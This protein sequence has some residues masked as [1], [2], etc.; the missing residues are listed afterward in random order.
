MVER[1]RRIRGYPPRPPPVP[2]PP[3]TPDTPMYLARRR[4]DDRGKRLP[5]WKYGPYIYT[6][7]RGD[8]KN[9]DY[10]KKDEFKL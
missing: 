7:T 9:Y 6:H 10:F 4:T 8:H 2:Y 1:S 5:E 3:Y